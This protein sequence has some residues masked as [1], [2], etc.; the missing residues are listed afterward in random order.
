M[1]EEMIRT[2]SISTSTV[3]DSVRTTDGDDIRMSA[4]SPPERSIPRRQIVLAVVMLALLAGFGYLISRQGWAATASQ[5]NGVAEAVKDTTAAVRDTSA[6][7]ATTVKARTALALSKRAAGLDV[8]VDTANAIVTLTGRAPTPEARDLAGQIVGDTS[9]VRGVQ[10]LLTVDPRMQP[11]QERERLVLRVRD[12]ETQVALAEMLQDSPD[13][14]GARIKVRVAD[15]VAT[16]EGT[17]AAEGQK[18]RAE[19]LARTFPNVRELISRLK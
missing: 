4:G 10:N 19:Q 7:A 5:V 13:L 11:E 6:D 16:L 14:L 17:S 9:G 2:D 1:G 12:L 3:D 8:N 18:V 15:G